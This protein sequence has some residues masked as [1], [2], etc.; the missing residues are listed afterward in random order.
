MKSSFTLFKLRLNLFY[1]YIIIINLTLFPLVVCNDIP[2]PNQITTDYFE[3]NILNS[4]S[5]LELKNGIGNDYICFYDY[6]FSK[7]INNGK[8]IICLEQYQFI[9]IF[10]NKDEHSLF[11]DLDDLKKNGGNHFS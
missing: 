11:C 2:I 4:G 1:F 9:Y 8:N 5:R 3:L 6:Y 10:N 7:A